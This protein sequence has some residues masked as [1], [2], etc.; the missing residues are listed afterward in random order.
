M[1]VEIVE[2]AEGVTSVRGFIV[3]LGADDFVIILLLSMTVSIFFR[4]IGP[5]GKMVFSFADIEWGRISISSSVTILDLGSVSVICLG[6][7]GTNGTST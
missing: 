6:G 5:T 7:L 3:F 1:G 4:A 2:I